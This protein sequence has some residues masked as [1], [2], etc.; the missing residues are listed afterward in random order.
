MS[1]T[2]EVECTLGNGREVRFVGRDNFGRAVFEVQPHNDNYWLKT[3]SLERAIRIGN[4]CMTAADRR[5]LRS[6]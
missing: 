1:T 2:S 3:T 5:W 6:R 4:G